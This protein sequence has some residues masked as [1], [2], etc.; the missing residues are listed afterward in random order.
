M[1]TE[2]LLHK[3]VLAFATVHTVWKGQGRHSIYFR[4]KKRPAAR[5][6]YRPEIPSWLFT[7]NVFILL[8]NVFVL[9]TIF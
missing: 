5:V 4:H 1:V 8:H 3:D 9:V 7:N 2:N 6:R